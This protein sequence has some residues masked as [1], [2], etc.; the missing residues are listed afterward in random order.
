MHFCSKALVLVNTV[1]ALWNMYVWIKNKSS[2]CFLR[3]STFQILLHQVLNTN[4][5]PILQV[6]EKMMSSR[7]LS[8]NTFD[9]KVY[10]IQYS[11]EFK[12]KF[13]VSNTRAY[14]NAKSTF[15]ILGKDQ[16]FISAFYCGIVV[17]TV[18][19]GQVLIIDPLICSGQKPIQLIRH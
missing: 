18:L 17:V 3:K 7:L 6:C 8:C 2:K 10:Y 1:F 12:C 9:T 4:F 11:V 5:I 16:I 14:L 19:I 15:C 13:H